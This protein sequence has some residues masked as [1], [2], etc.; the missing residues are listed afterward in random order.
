MSL[1]SQKL[2]LPRKFWLEQ[3][4][5]K[6]FYVEEPI[7]SFSFCQIKPQTTNAI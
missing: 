1:L 7:E 6:N 5:F 3:Q 4:Y 2:I